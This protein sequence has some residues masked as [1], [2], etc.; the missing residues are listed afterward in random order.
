M[1]LAH[2]FDHQLGLHSIPNVT[3]IVFVIDS[4]IALRSLHRPEVGPMN[5]RQF[6]EC[7]LRETCS[8]RNARMLAL[9]G[10]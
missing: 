4:D 6:G 1:S 5:R 9:I 8:R 10:E 7:L 3:P 2:T